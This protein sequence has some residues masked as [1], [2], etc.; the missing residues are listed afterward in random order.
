MTIIIDQPAASAVR[1]GPSRQETIAVAL[2]AFLLALVMRLPTLGNQSLW[3]DEILTANV[4]AD[5]WWALIRNRL[6]QGHFP[7]YFLLVKMLGLGH[8][9]DFMLRLPSA[10]FGSAAAAVA[11]LIALHIGGRIA[12]L[13]CMLMMAFIPSLIFYGQ[14]ARP[15]TLM[16]LFLTVM[17]FAQIGLLTGRG[18][19]D[20]LVIASTIGALG[21]A[22]S[23]PA[24]ILMVAAQQLA[25]W[26]GGLRSLED[27]VRSRVVRTMI[28]TWLVIGIAAL[29]L[30][31]NVIHIAREPNGM[32]RW[33]AAMTPADRLQKTW[34]DTFG[35]TIKN[36]LDRFLPQG[37]EFVPSLG[38]CALVAIGIVFGWQQRAIRY[39]AVSFGIAGL[40]YFGLGLTT[41]IVGRY[42]I[43]MVPLAALLASY[44]ASRLLGS[45]R[46]PVLVA[47]P[48]VMVA[49]L[50]GLQAL[51]AA[52]SSPRYDWRSIARFIT[53]SDLSNITILSNEPLLK[54]DLD[55]Y[56]P[57]D[58]AIET[59]GIVPNLMPVDVIWQW[60]RESETAWLLMFDTG[61]ELPADVIAGRKSCHWNFGHGDLFVVTPDLSKLPAPLRG[62]SSEP[63][64]N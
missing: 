64:G 56:L 48:I 16:L 58:V 3:Y 35:F 45:T 40:L 14:E 62:C 5:G 24:G 38:F 60:A 41:A 4:V 36:D 54:T 7:T 10:L 17:T 18:R 37:W 30:I 57:D 26:F 43:G 61:S 33:Q 28:A 42:L 32:M 15:Y 23:I 29:A 8:A 25:A 39:L 31:R 27:N 55:Y 63:A 50:L 44:G 6:A 46:R 9:S 21:T 59:R 34:N 2:S 20:W 51:D 1:P 13:S 12:A 49:M 22:F 47:V 11:T 52:T 53:E 19:A